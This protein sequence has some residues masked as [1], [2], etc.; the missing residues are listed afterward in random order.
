MTTLTKGEIVEYAFSVAGMNGA[1]LNPDSFDRENA[2]SALELMVRE[3]EPKIKI[4][5]ALSP[6]PMQAD[7]SDEAMVSDIA[8]SAL[9]NNLAIQVLRHSKQPVTVDLMMAA[10]NSKRELY[11]QTPAKR[12]RNT[13]MPLGQGYRR[14][15][16][17]SPYQPPD[18]DCCDWP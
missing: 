13:H 2:L 8:V 15:G 16:W 18:D 4:G 10:N 6:N 7:P 3:W 11:C 12:K 9:A 17:V 1:V 14:C 5:Y